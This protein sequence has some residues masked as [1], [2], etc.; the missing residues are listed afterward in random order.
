MSGRGRAAALA[1]ALAALAAARSAGADVIDEAF[2]AGSAAAQRGEWGAAIGHFEEA[3]RLLPGRSAVLSLDLGTAYAQIGDLGR[4]TYHLRRALQAEAEP[5]AEV[6]EAARRNLGIVRQRM[7]VAAAQAGAQ[8]D[9]PEGWWDL[10]LAAVRAPIFAWL[11]LAA[12]WLAV[13][14]LALRGRL[15][16]RGAAA[17]TGG[18]AWVLAATFVAIG[19]LHGLAVRGER[20]A[21]QAIVLP[22]SAEVRE[23]PGVHRPRA[24]VVQG[25]SRVRV[26]GR[27]AG[28]SQIRAGGGLEGW[29]PE[30]DLGMLD[31][32]R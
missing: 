23:A 18:L 2:A 22:A 30:G 21:P 31:A 20:A 17:T 8:I 10:V 25:G 3:Q 27:A 12:G 15:H 14:A 1:A 28:W 13:A 29:V 6:A 19:G 5:S 4:A 11:A 24:F 7:E 9:R 32:G 26:V 16:G